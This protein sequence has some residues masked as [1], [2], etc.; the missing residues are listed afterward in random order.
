MIMNVNYLK[1][2]H[3]CLEKLKKQLTYM[4]RSLFLSVQYVFLCVYHSSPGRPMWMKK[5]PYTKP[6]KLG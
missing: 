6:D 3:K 4:L 5:G 1:N 2:L